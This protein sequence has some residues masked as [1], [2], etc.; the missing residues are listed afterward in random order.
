VLDGRFS[1]IRLPGVRLR[2]GPGGPAGRNLSL[3]LHGRGE[4][5]F[6]MIGAT[7]AR[8]TLGEIAGAIGWRVEAQGRLP[9]KPQ[10]HLA[11]LICC[12]G[13]AYERRTVAVAL[14]GRTVGY[15]PS[16]LATRYREWLEEWR[17]S[18]AT[19]RC[20]AIIVGR[21]DPAGDRMV[22]TGLKLDIE[23]PFK[24]TAV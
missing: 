24:V 13:K 21:R 18:A 5:A 17:F 6:D 15:C 7:H 8:E 19:V 23:L 10:A 22:P 2:T 3:L 14:A 1:F 12:E 16:A 20:R 9:A 4:Y 11:T